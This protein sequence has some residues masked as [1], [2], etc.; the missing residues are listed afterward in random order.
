MNVLVRLLAAVKAAGGRPLGN[1]KAKQMRRPTDRVNI[2][3]KVVLQ[4]TLDAEGVSR[5][6]IRPFLTTL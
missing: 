1:N 4:I 5:L 6:S 2:D 3:D